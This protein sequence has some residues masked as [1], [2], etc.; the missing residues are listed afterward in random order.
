MTVGPQG[1]PP[2]P[3]QRIHSH[4]DHLQC[5]LLRAASPFQHDRHEGSPVVVAGWLRTGLDNL[6]VR[7][8][9]RSD[10]PPDVRLPLLRRLLRG[11][12]PAR[13]LL[14]ACESDAHPPRSH[15]RR[16][17]GTP[18]RN[19]AS[20]WLFG[21]RRLL[22]AMVRTQCQL[23]QPNTCSILRIH[24][25]GHLQGAQ[26]PP[27]HRW[28]ALAVHRLRLHDS[29]SSRVCLL[30]RPRLPKHHQGLVYYRGGARD[31]QEA[32]RQQW[33]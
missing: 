31:G 1:G 13:L 19:S 23:H 27:R 25:G 20:A 14:L 15:T 24:A 22:W 26:R 7:P 32:L 10:C 12:V 3:G 29:P 18:R 8:G 6:H 2:H 21:S 11:G 33:H 5:R 17:R 16:D 28:M 30:P 9:G 4:V